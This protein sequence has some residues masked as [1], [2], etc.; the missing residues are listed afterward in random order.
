MSDNTE[1]IGELKQGYID[2][3]KEQLSNISMADPHELAVITDAIKDMAIAEKECMEAAYYKAVT[4]AMEERGEDERMYYRPYMRMGYTPSYDNAV[5]N[6]ARYA[7]NA[8]RMDEPRDPEA[9]HYGRPYS[10]WRRARRNYTATHSEAD[11]ASMEATGSQYLSTTIEAMRD[12]WANADTTLKKRM[13]DELT[14]F[15]AGLAV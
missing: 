10:D 13:K 2:K 11:R 8:W 5:N 12:M 15:I 4:E 14:N 1:A 6:V 3:A 9:E 7:D